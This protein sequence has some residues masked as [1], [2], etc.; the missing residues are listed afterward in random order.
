[1]VVEKTRLL[2]VFNWL[3]WI[4]ITTY[5]SS[6]VLLRAISDENYTVLLLIALCIIGIYHLFNSI[7]KQS[8][9]HSGSSQ[10]SSVEIKN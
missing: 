4:T 1:M 3:F 10:E 7:A 8:V 9:A 5:F 6:A 2:P